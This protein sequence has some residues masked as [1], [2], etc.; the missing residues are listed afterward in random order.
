M[1]TVQKAP[2]APKFIFFTEGY[3]K[4]T[5]SLDSISSVQPAG[6]GS[7]VVLKEMKD[8]KNVEFIC[9]EN[10]GWVQNAIARLANS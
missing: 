8:G 4:R 9:S 10:Y 2:T 7:K 1:Q 6:Y 3:G 5:V